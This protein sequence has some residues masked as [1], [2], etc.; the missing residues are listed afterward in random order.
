MVMEPM[1]SSLTLWHTSE[2]WDDA[3]HRIQCPFSALF[4]LPRQMIGLPGKLNLISFNGNDKLDL[5]INT[6]DPDRLRWW[7]KI[8]LVDVAIH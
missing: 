4:T 1:A 6:H 3:T 7:S 8:I 5:P 2:G